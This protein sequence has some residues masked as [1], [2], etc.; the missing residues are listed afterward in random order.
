VEDFV[1]DSCGRIF[2]I[3]DYKSIA[4]ELK[5]LIGNHISFDNKTIRKKAVSMYGTEAFLN[6]LTE[7]FNKVIADYEQA[8]RN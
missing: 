6:R 3:R 8:N 5:Q 7:I 2:N 1:D 4:R